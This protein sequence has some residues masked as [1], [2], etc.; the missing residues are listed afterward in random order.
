MNLVRFH[1]GGLNRYLVDQLFRTMETNDS[2]QEYCG[3]VP[4]N[5]LENE[6][7]YR[8]ELS[9]PG[10]SKEEVKIS[11]QKN[12]LTI[13]SEKNLEDIENS[14][15][16]RRGFTP[17]NFEKNFQ[18]SKDIDGDKISAHF[19]NGILEVVLPKKEEVVEKAA[20]EIAI[21]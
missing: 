3:C 19:N 16:L 15:Y 6:K 17:Q 7:D 14:K 21:Q 20:I 1:N 8:L 13:K 10:F 2:R 4:S 11:V 18:L 5:V 12:V 9:I